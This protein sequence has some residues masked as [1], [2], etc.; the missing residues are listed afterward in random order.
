MSLPP[1]CATRRCTLSCSW[2]CTRSSRAATSCALLLMWRWYSTFPSHSPS[3][4]LTSCSSRRGPIWGVGA[5]QGEGQ[6]GRC[7]AGGPGRAGAWVQG[8]AWQ[9]RRWGPGRRMQALPHLVQPHAA[10]PVGDVAQPHVLR[11]LHARRLRLLRLQR[12]AQ[13]AG[14]RR[15][16][17]RRRG[18]GAAA[19]PRPRPRRRGPAAPALCRSGKEAGPGTRPAKAPAPRRGALLPASAAPRTSLSLPKPL[20]VTNSATSCRWPSAGAPLCCS[21]ALRLFLRPVGAREMLWAR[22]AP[23]QAGVGVGV[24]GVAWGG[25]G[26]RVLGRALGWPGQCPQPC[27]CVCVCVCARAR[28]WGRRL[29]TGGWSGQGRCCCCR[30]C[31]GRCAGGGRVPLRRWWQ[32]GGVL[33]GINGGVRR[34]GRP[35]PA[36]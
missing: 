20:L 26:R 30:C 29:P 7:L 35:G 14:C 8:Q 10:L 16:G 24:G 36:V 18:S 15:G 11:Q 21:S 13:A 23:G 3:S 19:G 31:W 25:S 4:T 2:L 33:Q 12:Q 28:A 5:E 22:A 1:T 34:V 27:V 32:G 6:G 9:Q 17:C